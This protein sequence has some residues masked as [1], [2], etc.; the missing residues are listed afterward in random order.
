MRIW[1]L[2]RKEAH[3]CFRSLKTLLS[4]LKQPC[5]AR[6]SPMRCART[7]ASGCG[8]TWIFAPSMVSIPRMRRV[9]RQAAGIGSGRMETPEGDPTAPSDRVADRTS[10]SEVERA[11]RSLVPGFRFQGGGPVGPRRWR[12]EIPGRKKAG[13]SVPD[14]NAEQRGKGRHHKAIGRTSGHGSQH[15]NGNPLPEPSLQSLL[16]ASVR[17]SEDESGS[18]HCKSGKPTRGL[19]AGMFS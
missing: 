8:I 3:P 12:E 4:V 2:S 16:A 18:A 17:G 10:R 14:R 19:I 13:W 11:V 6:E 9:Q 15:L 7:C 1:M 5:K